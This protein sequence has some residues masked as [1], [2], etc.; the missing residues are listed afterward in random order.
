M[1]CAGSL[2]KTGKRLNKRCICGGVEIYGAA[3]SECAGVLIN[4][5]M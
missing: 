4:P 2:E 1:D 5:P 3:T